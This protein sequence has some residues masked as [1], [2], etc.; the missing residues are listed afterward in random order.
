MD[1]ATK[2]KIFDVILTNA[3]RDSMEKEFKA[4]DEMTPDESA[5]PSPQFRRNVK[6]ITNSVGRKE[7][8]RKCLRGC[9]K[10][11]ISLAAVFGVLFGGLLTQPEV[12]A[13][14]QNV[15]RTVFEKYDSY[16][17]AGDELTVDNFDDSIRFGY[18]PEGYTLYDG[19]YSPAFVILTYINEYENEIYFDYSIADGTSIQLD[20]EH[21]SYYEFEQGERTYHYYESHDSDFKSTLLW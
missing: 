12:F 19:K 5:A 16:E 8:I 13:A 10:A 1:A 6:K 11:V 14:V 7:R 18:I 2:E 4:A 15:F 21:N 3:L 9:K 17:F 20:N